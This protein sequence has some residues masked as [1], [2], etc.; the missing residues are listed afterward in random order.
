[1]RFDNAGNRRHDVAN[2]VEYDV[3]VKRDKNTASCAIM[4]TVM[5]YPISPEALN[6]R[7]GVWQ[8]TGQE[9]RVLTF[10]GFTLDVGNRLFKNGLV[11]GAQKTPIVTA[12]FASKGFN[13]FGR[14]Y[15]VD[16][17]D[18]GRGANTADA[19]TAIDFLTAV[20]GGDFDIAFVAKGVPLERTY[21]IAAGPPLN[22]IQ[23]FK[24]CLEAL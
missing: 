8:G 11:A 21:H 4:I 2:S 20:W 14:L 17:G 22:I 12:A 1:M 15:D 7:A 6:F 3:E 16:M 9:N 10:T 24:D 5:N 23:R 19:Q 13:S 18:G